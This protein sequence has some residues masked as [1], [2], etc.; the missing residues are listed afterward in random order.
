MALQADISSLDAGPAA[1]GDGPRGRG[2]LKALVIGGVGLTIVGLGAAL[3]VPAAAGWAGLVLFVGIAVVAATSLVFLLQAEKHVGAAPRDWSPEGVAQAAIDGADWALVALGPG[4]EIRY[5]SLAYGRFLEKFGLKAKG[6]E[7]EPPRLAFSAH[8]LFA[9]ALLRLMRKSDG[10]AR[11]TVLVAPAPGQRP[12]RVIL[13]ERGFED[14]DG[15]CLSLFAMRDEGPLVVE[16]PPPKAA[17]Q[18]A[19]MIAALGVPFFTLLPDGRVASVSKGL[20]DLIGGKI[21]EGLH[22]QDLLPDAVPQNLLAQPKDGSRTWC[23]PQRLTLKSQTGGGS[24]PV[25]AMAMPSHTDRNVAIAVLPDAAPV[26]AVQAA[27]EYSA[28]GSP[29]ALFPRLFAEAPIGAAL[30]NSDGRLVASNP[31]L[32]TLL[33]QEIKGGISITQFVAESARADVKELLAE[34]RKGSAPA[35]GL[36]VALADSERTARIYAART[37]GGNGALIFVVDATEQKMLEQ[38]VSQSQKMKAVGQLAGG[39]AHDFNNL[40]TAIIGYS[41]LLLQSHPVGDPSFPELSQIHQTANR[42]ANLV[43]QL[44]AFSRR[45]T[46]RPSLLRLNDVFSEYRLFLARV[47]SERVSVEVS[48]GRDLWAVHADAGQLERVILNLAMN[49][50]DAM[51]DGGKLLI[52]TMNVRQTP[53]APQPNVEMPDGDYVLIEVEDTGTGIAREDLPKIF[54]P[55]YTTKG[56]GEGTG[57]GL[58]MVYGIVTQSGGYV[59]VDSEIG[60]GTLFRIYLPRY[61]PTLEDLQKSAEIEAPARS[62]DLTGR[63]TILLVEDEDAVRGFAVRSLKAKGYE[64]IE[65]A[66]AEE[67]LDLMEARGAGVDLIV[68]DVVMPGMDGPTLAGCI[69]EKWG[70]HKVILMSGYAEDSIRQN[71]ETQSEIEFMPKP[72]SLKELAKRVKDAL[73]SDKNGV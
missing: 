1:G 50:R 45:Q 55:F 48:L 25:T 52:R 22:I 71:L 5:A 54:E 60:K 70:P 66:S 72:F 16:A 38:Q 11:E 23:T 24:V 57:L 30:L 39:V 20:A 28:P 40:L 41:E 9:P 44:L 69:R 8:P 7:L 43:R 53:Q 34:V 36:E 56:V 73:H 27:P 61:E 3:A 32:A 18:P 12:H 58:S 68:S 42:A 26:T 2:W 6:G 47:M 62:Q 29:Q 51:P 46:M 19:A 67:A 13:E 49:A 65:A 33:G 10:Q 59:T 37:G 35:T 31:A 17:D 15:D 63:E 14:K 21:H 4:G 64:V